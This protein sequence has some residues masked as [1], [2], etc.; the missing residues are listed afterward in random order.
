[1]K[2]IMNNEGILSKTNELL[3]KMTLKEKIGQ[4]TCK[5]VQ[6]KGGPE[7]IKKNLVGV[8]TNIDNAKDANELQRYAVNETRLGIP[9]L[10]A[11]DVI[12]G[13]RTIFPIPV[14]EACSF[15]MEMIERSGEIAATEAQVGG[16]NLT[17]NPMLDISRDFRWGRVAE[18]SG[19]DTYLTEQTGKARI[20]GYKKAVRN[21]RKYASCMKHFVGYGACE[22]GRDYNT[23]DVSERVLRDVYL[24]PFKAAVDTGV[25]GAMPAFNVM[26]GIPCAANKFLMQKI[27]R[28]EMGFEGVTIS[29][30]NAICEL[31]DHGVALSPENAAKLALEAGTDVDINDDM[32]FHCLETLLNN[33]DISMETIDNAVRNVLYLKYEL[34][35][36]DNPYCKEGEEALILCDEH[37]KAARISAQKSS[38]LL[39]N[40]GVLPISNNKKVAVIGPLSEGG[41]AYLGWWKVLGKGDDVEGLLSGIK[42]RIGENNVSYAKG[43]DISDGEIDK[44]IVMEAVKDADVIIATLGEAYD[45][46]GEAKC[47]SN[48][49]LP[50]KQNELLEMLMQTG[51]PVVVTLIAGRPLSA[52]YAHDNANAILMMWQPGIQGGPAGAD[53]LFG[54]VNPSGKLC[55][56]IP[57][58]AAQIPVYYNHLNSGRPAES[59]AALDELGIKN[60]IF[61]SWENSNLSGYKDSPHTPLYPFCFGLSYTTFEYSDLKISN[62][63]LKIGDDQLVNVT[64]KNTGKMAGTEVVQ[65]YIQD[66]TGSVSRPVREL[67]GFCRVELMPGESKAVSITI[68]A[69]QHMFHN[70]E[71][72]LVYEPGLYRIWAGGSSQAQLKDTYMLVD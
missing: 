41:D 29:D 52:V 21:G 54:D 59:E 4:L 63:E 15:D 45:H 25:E 14:A 5:D 49:E 39:K 53:L 23:V 48:L 37:K 43:C 18:S 72:K 62:K 8:V 34:G 13:W 58:S 61:Y 67:K 65:I 2:Y 22:G 11:N 1:M 47:R 26:L 64:V 6:A 46:S 10:Y 38:V 55:V 28:E 19:E 9:Y 70:F 71:C 35:L 66:A 56:S 3:S 44:A 27:L 30:Y 32:Y 36:F 51:K 33:G 40:D 16:S 68:K 17:F 12:Q 31:M 20:T 57:R 7:F 60:N 50:G 42:N 24:P 69:E